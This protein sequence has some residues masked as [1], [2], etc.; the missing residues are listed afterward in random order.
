MFSVTGYS[1]ANAKQLQRDVPRGEL[2]EE[3][4]DNEWFFTECSEFYSM[5][6]EFTKCFQHT[7]YHKWVHDHFS[8]FSDFRVCSNF[9]TDADI[10]DLAHAYVYDACNCIHFGQVHN[11]NKYPSKKNLTF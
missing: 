9:Y 2:C 6:R 5:S 10:G 7:K 1:V 8:V 11:F 4:D 3:E